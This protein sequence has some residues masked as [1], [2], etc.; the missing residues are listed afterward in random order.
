M[1]NTFIR[2]LFARSKQYSE[3]LK[4][5]LK[6]TTTLLYLKNG[7]SVQE[8]ERIDKIHSASS[9]RVRNKI[10]LNRLQLQCPFLYITLQLNSKYGVTHH[11]ET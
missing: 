10:N 11:Y 7:N 9:G 3:K 4:Q 2:D 6:T 8:I 5:I 1:Q